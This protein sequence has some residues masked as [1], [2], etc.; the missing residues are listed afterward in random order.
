MD[1]SKL[2][3]AHSFAIEI[4]YGNLVPRRGANER[5]QEKGLVNNLTLADQHD[6]TILC[7]ALMTE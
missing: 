5:E 7:L 6:V 4:K 2:T 3:C 1:G